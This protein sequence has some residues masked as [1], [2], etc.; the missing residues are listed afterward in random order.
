MQQCTVN[1]Q[2]LRTLFAPP[3][4]LSQAVFDI[5]G[6]FHPSLPRVSDWF[7]CPCD[8]HEMMNLWLLPHSCLP[9]ARWSY[10]RRWLQIFEMQRTE[11]DIKLVLLLIYGGQ[12]VCPIL[13]PWLHRRVQHQLPRNV[14]K[15]VAVSHLWGESFTHWR[16]YKHATYSLY[17]KYIYTFMYT[18]F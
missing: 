2:R 9:R 18:F 8:H 3:L 11:D 7:L 15:P 12:S 6:M 5:S 13:Q 17:C 16:T 1:S 10:R 14:P 4:L